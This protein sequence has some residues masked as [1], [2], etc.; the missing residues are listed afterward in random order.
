MPLNRQ[1]LLPL[2]FTGSLG[3]VPLGQVPGLLGRGITPPGINDL[4]QRGA[5]AFTLQ[6]LGTGNPAPQTQTRG[7]QVPTLTMPA[8]QPRFNQ[9]ILNQFLSRRPNLLRLL[10]VLGQNDNVAWPTRPRFTG[11]NPL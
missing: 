9:G 10:Q 8:S 5:G 3:Q 1:G 4:V 11:I 6:P 2:P 7:P